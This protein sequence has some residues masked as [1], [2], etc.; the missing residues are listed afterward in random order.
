VSR[1]TKIRE[2]LSQPE[3]IAKLDELLAE[4]LG[5]TTLKL[6]TE[7]GKRTYLAHGKVDL[8]G[9]EA[10]ARTGGAGARYKRIAASLLPLRWPHGSR[11][12]FFLVC[13]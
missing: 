7:N 5:S 3:D 10:L 2:L 6:V 11:R 4:Q 8:F 12:P 9:E 13:N 1:L